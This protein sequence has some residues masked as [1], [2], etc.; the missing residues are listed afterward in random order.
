MSNNETHATVP[1][2][3][4]WRGARRVARLSLGQAAKQVGKSKTTLTRA[5]NAGRLSAERQEDGSYL[6]D[7]AEL[8]RVYPE[9]VPRDPPRDTSVTPLSDPLTAATVELAELRVRVAMQ[10]DQ[11]ARERDANDDLR[12]RLDRAEERVLAITAERKPSET[13]RGLLGWLWKG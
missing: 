4:M 5:I 8:G 3:A 11:L 2:C 12:R 7:V 1:W 10:A 6:I 9:T 13:R